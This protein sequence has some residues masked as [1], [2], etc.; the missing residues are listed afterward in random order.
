MHTHTYIHTWVFPF[1]Q[2]IMGRGRSLARESWSRSVTML[3]LSG[4]LGGRTVQLCWS[5]YRCVCVYVCV[6]V[7][8]YSHWQLCRRHD[9]IGVVQRLIQPKKDVIV[10]DRL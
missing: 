2:V 6:S 3:T 10:G 8:S 9:L 5:T 7:F 1:S 4:A